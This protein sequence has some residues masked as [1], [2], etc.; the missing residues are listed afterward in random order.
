MLRS[1]YVKGARQLPQQI[2][3]LPID[4]KAFVDEQAERYGSSQNSEIIRALRERMERVDK[5]IP[6]RAGNK[7]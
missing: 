5:E 6:A 1:R 3:R 7:G 2:V 4:V